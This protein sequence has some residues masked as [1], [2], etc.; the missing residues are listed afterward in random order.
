MDTLDAAVPDS[1]LGEVAERW[2]QGDFDP[3]ILAA[4]ARRDEVAFQL[5]VDRIRDAGPALI[6]LLPVKILNA[7]GPADDAVSWTLARGP[8]AD[9]AVRPIADVVAQAWW[10]LALGFALVGLWRRSRGTADAMLVSAVVIVPLALGLLALEAKGRYHEPVVPLVAGL[11]ALGV[12]GYGGGI[13]PR[14]GIPEP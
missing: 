4:A 9:R 10:V 12:A 8:N 11:A 1:G 6:A 5:A 7:W 14:S 2:S 13:G 3:A